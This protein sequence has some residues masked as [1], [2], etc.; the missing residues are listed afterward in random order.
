MSNSEALLT[1]QL[2]LA[3]ILAGS[4][5][6]PV[7]L[8]PANSGA[9]TARI[10]GRYLHS[11][12]DPR[13][14]GR[15]LA[16]GLLVENPA[17]LLVFFGAG[18]G[19]GVLEALQLYPNPIVWFEPIGSVLRAALSLSDVRPHLRSG[20]LAIVP[21]MPSDDTLEVLFR[22]RANADIVF[23]LHRASIN[24]NEAYELLARGCESYLNRKGVNLATLSRFDRMWAHN[25]I[26]NVPRL[27]CARPV[28]EL[29]GSAPDRTAVVCGAGPSLAADVA[30]LAE[31]RDRA[32]VIAVDTAVAVLAQGGIDPDI[33]VSVDPQPVNY[34]YLE[35]YCGNACLV[36][37]P[38]T[39]YLSLRSFPC[40]R[41]FVA[42]SPVP[43]AKYLEQFAKRPPGQIAFGGSVSTNAY[44]LAVQMG[45]RDIVLL[46]QDLAFTD[47]LAHA[48]GA[49]LEARILLKEERVF[50]HELH[51]YRQLSALPV[52]YLPSRSGGRLPTNDKLVIFHAWFERRFARD[53]A[54]GINLYDCGTN[55]ALHSGAK[56][57]SLQEALASQQPDFWVPPI[58]AGEPLLDLDGLLADLDRQLVAL[59]AFEELSREASAR[60][61]AAE[62]GGPGITASLK[63]LDRI[64]ER[65]RE[66][67]STSKIISGAM[68]RTIFEITE[69]FGARDAAEG[70]LGR[71]VRLYDALAESCRL[72]R[73]WVERLIRCRPR[74]SPQTSAT[75]GCD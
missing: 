51:N 33:I 48:R 9:L 41:V 30:A 53:T 18:L 74:L 56:L 49:V 1:E 12:H 37:D 62:R 50:R 47:G 65:L 19:N 73:S 16:E 59:E 20:R 55:G 5:S 44:D 31:L 4:E 64:D 17:Q 61:R 43:I 52:R 70:A 15:R 54:S 34:F 24:A 6:P 75:D 21:G 39:S 13:K 35:A 32:I 57:L 3:G 38:T 14:E 27:A 71:S 2:E 22:G 46:G 69:H 10:G 67:Q 11:R 8:E 45:C 63:E 36:V 66:F 29:F 58:S 42:E 72:H 60:A 68:Q 26:R 23:A 7:E 28:A 25:V 40:E